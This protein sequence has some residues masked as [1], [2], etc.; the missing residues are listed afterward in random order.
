M[1]MLPRTTDVFVIGGG[2]AGLAA[3]I[4]A[5][6]RGLDVTLAD[7]SVPPVDKACG[8]GI[9]PDGLAAARALGLDLS[10]AP[11]HAF[12]GIRFLNAG[13][14]VEADFPSGAGRGVRRVELHRIMVD[15]ALAAGVRLAWGTRIAGIS[16]KGVQAGDRM[17]AAR[18]IVGADGSHSPVRVG[19]GWTPRIMRAAASV[20]AATIVWRIR[21]I[22]WSCIGAM[23]ASFM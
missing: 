18:W 9:M 14:G 8:E 17:V 15:A 7:C 10:R 1:T 23:P 12:R 11:G 2:P 19:P 13:A 21:A 22:T 5:R 6:R 3:A 4:A 20:S 16:S